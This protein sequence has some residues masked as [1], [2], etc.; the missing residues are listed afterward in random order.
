M[1]FFWR[2]RRQ[3]RHRNK[4]NESSTTQVPPP[5]PVPAPAPK[6]NQGYFAVNLSETR[7]QELSNSNVDLKETSLSTRSNSP[8]ETSFN[9]K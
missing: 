5:A 8:T 6:T 2:I 1:H 3:L 4:N 9:R 7:R